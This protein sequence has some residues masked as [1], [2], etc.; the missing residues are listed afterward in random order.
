[1]I[2]QATSGELE[3][4]AS[5]GGAKEL[6]DPVNDASEE[7]DVTTHEG[8]KS[9]SGV[10]VATGDVGT[11]SDGDKEAERVGY[12]GSDQAGRG[13]GTVCSQLG[14]GHARALTGEHEYKGGDKL[15][16]PCPQC[17]RVGR[18]VCL[19]HADSAD[20]HS[21]G[22]AFT[23]SLSL[24]VS[25]CALS[26]SCLISASVLNKGSDAPQFIWMGDGE[27]G[28]SAHAGWSSYRD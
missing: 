21:V 19:P 5:N 25:L 7:R 12:G 9:D 8:A 15:R 14:E 6:S 18:L 1:M 11:D 23:L 22:V 24:S 16:Q 26:L 17:V 13:S 2:Y 4:Q 20:R 10:D 27:W 3:Q 28:L